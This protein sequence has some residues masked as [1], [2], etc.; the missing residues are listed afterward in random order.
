MART[1]RRR[2][3]EEIVNPH[4]ASKKIDRRNNRKNIKRKINEIDTQHIDEWEDDD[5]DDKYIVRGNN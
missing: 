5:D 3:N 1:N 4:R 2:D